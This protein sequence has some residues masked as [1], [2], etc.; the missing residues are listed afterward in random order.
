VCFIRLRQKGACA[1]CAIGINGK[2]NRAV[3]Q[4]AKACWL[5]RN[6]AV[7]PSRLLWR[8]FLLIRE[9]HCV[10]CCLLYIIWMSVKNFFGIRYRNSQ[11]PD[12]TSE[13]YS[14][15]K[16]SMTATMHIEITLIT[17]VTV[18]SLGCLNGS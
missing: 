18:S 10:F 14:F 17:E 7:M 9:I 8:A 3:A 15:P 2:V 13:S 12:G 16:I 4:R 11:L 6:S 1:A 5:R